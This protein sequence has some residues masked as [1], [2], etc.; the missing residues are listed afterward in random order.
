M[1]IHRDIR[2]GRTKY[3]I[4]VLSLLGLVGLSYLWY[5][6]QPDNDS[7]VSGSSDS[8][9]IN[10][11]PP[12]KAEVEAGNKA[13]QETIEDNQDS[14]NDTDIPKNKTGSSSDSF[15]VQVL[16]SYDSNSDNLHVGSIISGIHSNGSCRLTLTKG[17]QTVRRNAGIQAT[18]QSSTCK[19]FNVKGLSSGSWKIDLAITIDNKTVKESSE[20]EI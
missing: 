6:S 3:I 13:K 10:Y 4:I 20:I 12:T 14:D 8:D 15:S 18:A 9:A 2:K 17:D 7:Y 5:I 1:K 16:P 11:E 19:G